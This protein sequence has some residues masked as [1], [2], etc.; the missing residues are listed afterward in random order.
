MFSLSTIMTLLSAASAVKTLIDTGFTAT[1]LQS[2]APEIVPVLEQIADQLLPKVAP[3]ARI[4]AA[5]MVTFDP[6]KTKWL[7]GALNKYLTLNPPLK[8]D[9]V[10][11]TKTRD[12]VYA[13]QAKL[14]GLSV[15]GWAG[16]LTNAAL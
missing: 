6:N 9:G 1:S 8:V 13:A 11:G 16:K 14:T 5:A 2:A 12:A 10:Y 3:E 4:V 15:D 7:Q